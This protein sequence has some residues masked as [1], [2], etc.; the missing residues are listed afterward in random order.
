MGDV[1]GQPPHNRSAVVLRILD[2][3]PNA[4]SLVLLAAQDATPNDFAA[5]VCLF[6]TSSRWR[7]IF[8]LS[9]PGGGVAQ[10][11]PIQTVILPCCC[12][13]AVPR[14]MK[15]WIE[16][17]SR[18]YLRAGHLTVGRPRRQRLIASEAAT[19]LTRCIN[20]HRCGGP[21][22]PWPATSAKSS[23]A[24]ANHS[25]H[26]KKIKKKKKRQKCLQRF[27]KTQHHP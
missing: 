14:S 3:V 23:L 7:I 12:M 26:H 10:F 25:A 1:A 4:P 6:S 18:S 11:L 16:R 20:R 9:R 8:C 13:L 2:G 27:H 22:L 5:S 24:R 21:S 17:F 15:V 19:E